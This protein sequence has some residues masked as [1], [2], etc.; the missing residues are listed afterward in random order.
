MFD[1]GFQLNGGIIRI[2]SSLPLRHS[3]D[4]LGWD[5]EKKIGLIVKS[6]SIQTAASV[7][8]LFL[9]ITPQNSEALQQLMRLVV[10]TDQPWRTLVTRYENL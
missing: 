5:G 9:K 1:L 2:P 3:P 10:T 6:E 8:V 7:A 4:R